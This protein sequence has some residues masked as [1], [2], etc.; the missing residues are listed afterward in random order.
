[1]KK[2]LIF[3]FIIF[4]AGLGC[5]KANVKDSD[6]LKVR[7]TLSYIQDTKTKVITRYPDDASQKISVVFTDSLNFISFSGVCNGGG[8]IYSY[9]PVTHEIKITILG[10]TKIYCKYV[11]WEAYT[12]QSLDEALSYKINGNSLVICSNGA[13]NLYFNN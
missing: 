8:G 13:Y 10:S 2:T 5:E 4:L 9:S 3:S 11:D 7:W 1:M 12:A 6:L